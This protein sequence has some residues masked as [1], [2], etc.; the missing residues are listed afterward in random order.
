M[1]TKHQAIHDETTSTFPSSAIA[2]WERMV[3]D[4]NVDPKKAKNPYVEV[5]AG[6]I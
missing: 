2:E 5:V 1:R 4:W 6:I 3:E